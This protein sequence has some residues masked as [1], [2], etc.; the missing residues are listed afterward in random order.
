MLQNKHTGDSSFL[1]PAKPEILIPH[2]VWQTSISSTTQP[3]HYITSV[4]ETLPTMS[5]LSAKLPVVSMTISMVSY[6]VA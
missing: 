5:A 3:L 6:H 1:E 4:S 2:L